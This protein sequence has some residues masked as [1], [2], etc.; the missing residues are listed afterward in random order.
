[1]PSML[2]CR[3]WNPLTTLAAPGSASGRREEHLRAGVHEVCCHSSWLLLL[4]LLLQDC[5]SHGAA[6]RMCSW[7]CSCCRCQGSLER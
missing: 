5:N 6:H 3:G 1:M 2:C 4:L 7:R